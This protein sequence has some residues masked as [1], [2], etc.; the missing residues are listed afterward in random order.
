MSMN[1][2]HPVPFVFS[3]LLAIAVIVTITWK[4]VLLIQDYIA[5]R[6]GQPLANSHESELIASLVDNTNRVS[7]CSFHLGIWT[8][9]GP[10]YRLSPFGLTTGNNEAVFK[11][12]YGQYR[13]IRKRYLAAWKD[14]Q[15]EIV[16]AHSRNRAIGLIPTSAANQAIVEEHR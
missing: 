16:L 7:R 9:R 8:M 10:D 5:T 13:R 2:M 11:L 15:R 1:E 6:D 14:A 4:L 3:T 12:S